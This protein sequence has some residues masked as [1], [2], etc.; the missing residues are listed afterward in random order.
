M[1]TESGHPV[2]RQR[3]LLGVD[4]GQGRL[5]T[6]E[7][8]AVN[9][10]GTVIAKNTVT[11]TV[12]NTT[13]A[14]EFDGRD[15]ADD[16]ERCDVEG[17]RE[18]ACGVRRQRRQGRGRS[19]LGP[20]RRRRHGRVDRAGHPF[21]DN[22]GFWAS[23]SVKDGTHTFE[24]RAV[25]G[26]GTVIAKNTVTATVANTTTPPSTGDQVAPSQPGNLKVTSASATN[27]GVA[28]S[29]ATDNVGVTGYDVYRGSTL[30][31]TTPQT[32]ATL[33]GLSCGNAYQV[34]V[35]AN[36]AA[37]N[38]SPPATMAVTTSPCP[39][40]QA[41]SAP[42]NVT[43][44]TRT[45][46]SIA[47]TW[48]PATDNVGVAGYGVYNAGQLVNTTAGT[49]GIV[50]GLTCG[51]N[52]TL[53][54]DAFDAT[55]NS[56]AKTT[57]MVSTLPCS[58]TQAPSTPTGMSASN[59]TQ[60]GATVKWNAASDNVGVTGY[61]VYRNGTKV[62]TVTTLSTDQSGLSCGT[63][64]TFAVAARDA[65][66]NQSAQ[67]QVVVTTATC[68]TTTPP[69]STISGSE[70]SSRAQGAGAVIEQVTVN[71]DCT[72]AAQNVTIR[73]ATIAGTV[74]FTP[75]ASG[76]KL[77]NSTAEGFY[78]FGADNVVLDGNT[79]DAHGTDN[80]NIIWDEPAG[81]TPDGWVIR[82]NAIKNVYDDA[83]PSSHNE[84]IYVG[85]S[86]NGLIENNTFTNN[87]NTAHL[88]FTNFGNQFNDSSYPRNICVRGNTFQ[89]THGAYFDVNLHP[90][91][92]SVG[93]A[94]TGIRVSTD[95]V[96]PHGITDKAFLVSC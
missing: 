57:V 84:G 11:A 50:S 36:D 21:G 39:D 48:A 52:Y 2:W 49:T 29:P 88:F 13:T 24:V 25:N 90:N 16:R 4:L 64:Y 54:V 69:A 70:C 67:A 58:D 7:V 77:L 26:S 34:G 43:A 59:V 40:S 92:S 8:R 35:D 56:S 31:T 41:P 45:T 85:Y 44:S 75:S 14:A 51:T 94:K 12:A 6:F 72:V 38:S 17:C 28:W 3:R 81:N 1:S 47:L 79:L 89:Q 55:G 78:I 96:M 82:G 23:T 60:T 91:V 66:G 76:G 53:A 32:N 37:G 83:D 63:A 19:G 86:T 27:V 22:A 33:T 30:T 74:K 62:T 87:G 73:N 9:G 71:G 68:S 15:H 65:A 20:V 80:L 61:D 95:N 46:T 5:H 42:T 93:Q 10:S 18:L